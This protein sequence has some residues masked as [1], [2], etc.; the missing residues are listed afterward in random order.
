MEWW[1]AEASLALWLQ[2][3]RSVPS[4]RPMLDQPA[5]SANIAARCDEWLRERLEDPD[6]S[7]IPPPDLSPWITA[8]LIV[9]RILAAKRTDQ[10]RPPDRRVPAK[11]LEDLL[12][13]E[14]H[15]R[16]C[17]YWAALVLESQQLSLVE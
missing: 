2:E 16:L 7:Q 1:R 5:C 6:L 17:N 13:E 8:R 12:I 3:V 10:G 11:L 14:W 4:S 15:S 9:A